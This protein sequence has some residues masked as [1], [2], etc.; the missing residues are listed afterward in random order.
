MPLGKASV[1]RFYNVSG[2]RYQEPNEF[3]NLGFW[4]SLTFAT[5]NIL[6]TKVNLC[7]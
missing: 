3:L 7:G 1:V 4:R 6:K 2:I 5:S